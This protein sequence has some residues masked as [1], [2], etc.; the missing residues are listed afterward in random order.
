MVAALFPCSTIYRERQG[1]SNLQD[2]QSI[3]S[4]TQTPTCNSDCA[5]VSLENSKSFS[6]ARD[7]LVPLTTKETFNIPTSK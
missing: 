5:S 3:P 1:I 2:R 7:G 6:F 4:P